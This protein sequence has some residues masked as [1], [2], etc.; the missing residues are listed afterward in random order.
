MTK[1]AHSIPVKSSYNAEDY[2]RLYIDE[3]VRWHRIPL[4][5]ILDEGAQFTSH[6]KR[7]FQKSLG[8]QLKLSTAFNPQI[9]W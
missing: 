3:I 2:V 7:S 6:L 5:I 8:T 4:F 9:D 1:S